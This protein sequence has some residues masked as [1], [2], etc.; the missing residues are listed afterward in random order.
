MS[1]ENL[2]AIRRL[3]KHEASRESILKLLSAAERNLADSRAANISAE[4]RFDA[5]YKVIMQC[6]TAA[7]W[8][9]GY[10]TPTS[11][12][13]HH[14][15][16]IQTLPKTIGLDQ[17]TVIVLDA[18]RKQ[19][20]LADYAGDSVSDASL[21]ECIGQAERLFAKVRKAISATKSK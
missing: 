15:T 20:N 9:K 11:E 14:Q 1:L 10:R 13:G 2:L 4:N 8:M 5:A 16:T 19:R 12:A 6:A 21:A 3:Q 17:D 7:L 18:L